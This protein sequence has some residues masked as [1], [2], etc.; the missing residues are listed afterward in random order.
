MSNVLED[1]F[2]FQHISF[3]WGI[4]AESTTHKNQRKLRVYVPVLTPMRNGDISDKGSIETITLFNVVTQAEETI[5]VH[6]T[7]TILADYLG[8]Q[9]DCDVPDMYKGQQVLVMNYHKSDKWFWIPMERDDYIKTFGHC[10]I[11]CADISAVHKMGTVDEEEERQVNLNDDNTY[12][13]EIDTKYDKKIKIST[14]ASDGEKYRY[15]LKLDPTDHTV[16]IW[17]SLAANPMAPH[18]TIRIESDPTYSGDML[19]GRITLQNE[20]GCTLQ[21]Q[22]PDVI[23]KAVRDLTIVSGRNT[24]IEADGDMSV[25]VM[26]DTEV[27]L[28]G[29]LI[30]KVWGFIKAEVVG[31]YTYLFGNNRVEDVVGNYTW[32]C[33][34]YVG[35]AANMNTTVQG[36]YVLQSNTINELAQNITITGSVGTSIAGGKQLTFTAKNIGTSTHIYGCCGCP[37]H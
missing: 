26:A 19:Q 6:A 13:I 27:K 7:R 34:N 36:V 17:D 4:L 31:L 8:F 1:S 3:F 22:G 33:A 18:N 24:V 23:L 37:G 10:R 30:R 28:H 29:N 15:F 21:L 35:T 5:D 32:N 14:S 16:E 11:R 2:S 12:Y 9:E 25:E 20:A